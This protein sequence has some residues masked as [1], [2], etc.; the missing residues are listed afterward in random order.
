MAA[1]ELAHVWQEL[2]DLNSLAPDESEG[3][4]EYAAYLLLKAGGTEEGR[5][6][7]AAMKESKDPAYGLGFRKAL[8]LAGGEAHAERV[9]LV[10]QVGRGWPA[11]P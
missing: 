1:H 2:Q 6:K 3:S 4:A 5:I 8:R 11:S 7:I 10:L 9:R